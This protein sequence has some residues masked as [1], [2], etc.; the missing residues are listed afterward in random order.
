MEAFLS[1]KKGILKESEFSIITDIG[2]RLI[3]DKYIVRDVDKYVNIMLGDKKNISGEI[4]I[5][6]I[7]NIGKV[8]LQ[9]FTFN[10]IF[11]IVEEYNEYISN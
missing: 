4:G 5:I 7:K 2:Q 10:E 8:S 9:Y 11:S 3:S 6:T 1:W